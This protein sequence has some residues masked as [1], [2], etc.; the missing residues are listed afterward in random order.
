MM[1]DPVAHDEK[2]S[3]ASAH[4]TLSARGSDEAQ[5]CVCAMQEEL[6]ETKRHGVASHGRHPQVLSPLYTVPH[7]TWPPSVFR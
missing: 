3:A 6:F 2:L 1:A 4:H 7:C 5:P